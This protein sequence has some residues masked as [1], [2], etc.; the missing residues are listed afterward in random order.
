MKLTL[1]LCCGLASLSLPRGCLGDCCLDGDGVFGG[2]PYASY[3]CDK[4][5]QRIIYTTVAPPREV[6]LSKDEVAKRDP[7]TFYSNSDTMECCK[8]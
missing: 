6:C 3:D 4:D 7:N 2:K 5:Q 1:A 8:A